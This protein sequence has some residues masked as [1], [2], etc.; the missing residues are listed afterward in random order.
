MSSPC[1]ALPEGVA[2]LRPAPADTAALR[3]FQDTPE[4][5]AFAAAYRHNVLDQN[6]PDLMPFVPLDPACWPD[7]ARRR[8]FWAYLRGFDE[9]ADPTDFA[10]S[11]SGY[12]WR[13]PWLQVRRRISGWARW[14]SK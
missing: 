12:E 5:R 3:A 13:P 4:G 11:F 10:E 1:R 8:S 14:A 2:A 9:E 7:K 6:G